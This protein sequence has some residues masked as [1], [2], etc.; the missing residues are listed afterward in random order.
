MGW[1]LLPDRYGHRVGVIHLFPPTNFIVWATSNNIMSDKPLFQMNS[2]E[3]EKYLKKHKLTGMAAANAGRKR[4]AGIKAAGV[5]PDQQPMRP[6]QRVDVPE[7]EPQEGD[8]TPDQTESQYIDIGPKSFTEAMGIFEV[9]ILDGERKGREGIMEEIR[10]MGRIAD[11]LGPA[12]A[13]LKECRKLTS[14]AS[15]LV[16]PADYD[17]EHS[18][19]TDPLTLKLEAFFKECKDL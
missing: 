16:D 8:H 18:V 4:R 2:S 9:V 10:R 19:F 6:E 15:R 12:L 1:R 7:N 17:G 5:N 3:F 14:N 11:K 13:L